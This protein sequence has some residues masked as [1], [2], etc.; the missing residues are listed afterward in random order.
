MERTLW[1][2]RKNAAAFHKKR[3]KQ[4]PML[5]PNTTICLQSMEN[6][7]EK[8]E[9]ALVSLVEEWKK[10]R[11]SELQVEDHCYSQCCWFQLGD[12]LKPQYDE[13]L[14]RISCV[15]SWKKRFV[16][17]AR[18]QE[19]VLDM[20]FRQLQFVELIPIMKM[21]TGFHQ[22]IPGREKEPLRRGKVLPARLELGPIS[23]WDPH[24][25]GERWA[26]LKVPKA[27]LDQ[28]L[29]K[30]RPRSTRARIC[31]GALW[32]RNDSAKELTLQ[33]MW[34]AHWV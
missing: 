26:Y 5:I 31:G 19:N 3:T 20:H 34:L 6:N 9:T 17:G 13:D 2:E 18:M 22:L 27:R 8:I 23:S 14:T 1:R 29:F 15:S 10:W 7:Y 24:I 21:F 12:H 25:D 33:A 32:R 11:K 30:V 16:D 28:L 4:E